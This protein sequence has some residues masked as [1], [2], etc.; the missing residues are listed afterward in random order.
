D[1]WTGL[2]LAPGRYRFTL[3]IEDSLTGRIG[4][5]DAET[6]VPDPSGPGLSLST[7]VLASNLSDDGS[8]LEV[9]GRPTGTFH[10]SETLGVYYEVYGLDGGDAGVFATSS[11]FYREMPDGSLI[12]LGKPLVL[13]KRTGEAQGWSVPLAS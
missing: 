2:A 6:D 8:R 5:T 1:T 9:T 3:A 10:R 13:E 4:R 11:R 7:L 12:A